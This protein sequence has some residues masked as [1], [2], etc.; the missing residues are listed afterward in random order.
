MFKSLK[1]S[2]K[3][4]ALLGFLSILVIVIGY[5]GL[6]SAELANKGLDTVYKDRVVPL[7]GL[8][9]VADM[10]AV[11]IVDTSHK[12]RNGNMKWSEGRQSV[13]TA[14]RTINENWKA[15][16]ATTLVT[17]E[18]E[19]VNQVNPLMKT[20]DIGVARL[21]DILKDEDSEA[22]SRFTITELYPAIDPISGKFSELV[23]VQLKVAKDE[24]DKSIRNYYLS[25]IISIV[26]IVLGIMLSV[27]FG[28]IIS[29]SITNP[30]RQTTNMLKD[31]SEGEG[32]LTKRLEVHG[33]DE[34][35]RL[36]E[37]FNNFVEK[38][39]GIITNISSNV[40]I[41]AHSSKEFA[42]IS[43]QLSANA[44]ETSDKCAT[45]ATATEE[46]SSNIQSVSAAM[47]ESTA[48]VNMVVSSTEEMTATVQEI[49]KS[50]EKARG[51]SEGAV[52]Q[53]HQVSEQMSVLGDSAGKIGKV[54]ETITEISEQ[55]N[56]LALNATIEAA[57][58]GEA[59]KGFAVVAN[60]IKELARQTAAAT[61]DIK[62]QIVDMQTTTATA[63][64]GIQEISEVIAEVNHV[65][66][67]IATAV[68]EQS[69][70]TGEIAGNI[71][72]SSQGIAEVN[73]NVAQATLVVADI[74]QDI[75]GI[76]Q[77]SSQVGVG[78]SQVQTSAQK[79]SELAGELRNLVARFKV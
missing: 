19:L 78:S 74:T 71:A 60:E 58:A 22:L 77:Q 52:T 37:Y 4:N 17:E 7:K 59:G 66:N 72:Q 29:R 14:V 42:T 49:A 54:T 23:E 48:S 63:V 36:S 62:N 79:L 20:A 41:L 67:G 64:K 43:L 6:Q 46:M 44:K 31:I 45:V 53:S 12:V 68:E 10:Y 76:N 55:T 40:D 13:E 1:I 47:E 9:V 56:L 18:K 25:R 26:A 38:L 27:G 69:A 8:K 5:I 33:T 34:V 57:R 35:S 21:Y 3:L 2:T 50:A 15:Y 11:N 73:E 28:F 65:I 75:A 32:D 51:I 39:Q 30:I 61:V 24:Y 70:A 16:L